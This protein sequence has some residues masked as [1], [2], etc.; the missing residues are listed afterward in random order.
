MLEVHPQH[1]PINTVKEFLIHMLAITLGLMIALG[2]EAGVQLHEHHKL[3]SEAR[4]NIATEIRTN[5]SELT[6]SLSALRME[7]AELQKVLDFTKALRKDRNSPVP[8]VELNMKLT[9]LNRSSWDTASAIGALNYM[10]YAQVKEYEDVYSLQ[11]DV[12]NLQQRRLEAW[13]LMNATL[14]DQ[15]ASQANDRLIDTAEQQVRLSRANTKA[16]V[17]LSQS[18]DELYTQTLAEQSH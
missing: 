10:E 4:A 3:A 13:L 8:D 1:K 5:Q 17:S 12:E 7:D 11:Q 18:L 15:E 14:S 9:T 2:M 16:A 6:R